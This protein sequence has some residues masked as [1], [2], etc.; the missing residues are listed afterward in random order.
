MQRKKVLCENLGVKE[1]QPPKEPGS[2]KFSAWVP[3]L[4]SAA[5]SAGLFRVAS[6]I[7]Q[8]MLDLALLAGSVLQCP[9]A[10][11]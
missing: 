5:H 3:L 1:A 6:G 10:G 4:H 11:F 8:C 9:I 2:P 7:S